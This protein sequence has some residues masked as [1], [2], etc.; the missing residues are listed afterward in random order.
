ML[1][2]LVEVWSQRARLTL[3]VPHRAF[4]A[5]SAFLPSKLRV[6]VPCFRIPGPCE[7]RLA[8]NGHWCRLYVGSKKAALRRGLSTQHARCKVCMMTYTSCVWRRNCFTYFEIRTSPLV[9]VS[10]MRV[11]GKLRMEEE[12]VPTKFLSQCLYFRCRWIA[13][14]YLKAPHRTPRSLKQRLQSYGTSC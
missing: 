10:S 1:H 9:G 3:D 8:L 4:V 13:F 6:R 14:A 7:E 11:I 5:N 12:A 2:C